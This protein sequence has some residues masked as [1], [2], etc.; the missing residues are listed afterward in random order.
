[1]QAFN[2]LTDA[3]THDSPEVRAAA[4][5][6]LK[7]VS[8]SVKNLSAGRFMNEAVIIPLVQLLHDTCTSVQFTLS[9]FGSLFVGVY[10]H[11]STFIHCGGVKQLVRLSKSMD[12]TIRVNAVWALKNLMFLVNSKCKEEILPELLPS[13]L[14]RL[15]CDPESSVQEQALALVRNLVDRDSVEYVFS[16]E[17][18]LLNAIGRQMLSSS[19]VEVLIQGMYV[20]SNVASGNEFHKEAVM[21]QLFLQAGSD[22]QTILIKFLQSTDS[23]LRTASVSVLVNLTLTSSPGANSRVI[24]L[25]KCGIVSQLKN[26]INDPCLDVKLHARTALGQ[27]MMSGDSSMG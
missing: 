21:N 25:Q 5:I 9:M 7:N 1:M 14:I 16:E 8:R 12:S 11:K 23:R 17:G 10:K 27:S 24:K 3:L 18:L 13:T 6:C 19:N 15:I 2:F 4:C 22:A 26:M 20:L